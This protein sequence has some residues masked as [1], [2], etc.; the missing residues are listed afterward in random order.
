MKATHFARNDRPLCGQTGKYVR[1][2]TSPFEVTCRTCRGREAWPV[3]VAA[4]IK[5]RREAIEA[6]P[7][8]PVTNPWN[9]QP[10]TC[11]GCGN[12]TFKDAGRS[13][14]TYNHQCAKCGLMNHT[15][16]E[17]GMSA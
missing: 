16:T 6:S 2:S 11:R 8:R 14:D 9:G 17:T 5:A 1:T 4:A 3:I 13:L 10:I 15:M 7:A 12:D